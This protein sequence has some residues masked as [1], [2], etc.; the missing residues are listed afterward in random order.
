ME[1]RRLYFEKKRS[2]HL[3][4]LTNGVTD[5]WIITSTGS[6]SRGITPRSGTEG[7]MELVITYYPDYHFDGAQ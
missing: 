5:A 6:V 7:W 1:L 2:G 4:R 3:R